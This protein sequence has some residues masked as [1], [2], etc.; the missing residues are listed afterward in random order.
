[1]ID[2]KNKYDRENFLDFLQNQLL[3]DDFVIDTTPLHFDRK[4]QNISKIT[5]L[6]FVKSLGKDVSNPLKVYELEH[7]SENDPRVSLKKE[8]FLLL[9]DDQSSRSLVI[10]KSNNSENYRFSLMTIDLRGEGKQI[11]KQ[12]SNPRRYSFYLGPDAKIKTPT[13]FLIKAEAK[14][15][16]DLLSR[17]SIE[18]VNKEFYQEVAR[19]FYELVG[20][21][22]RISTKQEDHKRILQ[23]PSADADK[24]RIH[25]EFAIRLIGRII[26][27]WFL[28]QKNSVGGIPLLPESLLSSKTVLASSDYYHSVLEKIFFEALNKEI[29][30]RNS[31]LSE[32]FNLI[33]FLNGGLFDPHHEDFYDGL[34]NKKL[35]IPDD[36]F[37]E[38]FS[39]LETYNFTIDEN[40]IADI[41]ISVDP[42]MLGRI[43]ENLLAEVNP[44]TGD[45]ARKSTGSYYTPRD[46]V[47]YMVDQ[48]LINYLLTKTSISEDK[49]AALVSYDEED[50]KEK[51]L[52]RGEITSIIGALDEI[53]IIDPACGSGAFPIGMLQK[54]IMIL[55]RIDPKAK[56]WFEKKIEGID[57]LI[58]EDYIKRFENENFDYIRKAGIIRDS[59]YGV[60]IQPIAVEVSKLRCFLTLI[61]NEE[62]DDSAPNRGVEPLPNLDYKI[63][64]GNSLIEIL[65]PELLQRTSDKEKNILINELRDLKDEVFSIHDSGLKKKKKEEV[66]RLIQTIIEYERSIEKETVWREILAKKNQ[67]KMFEDEHEQ[68][69][70]ADVQQVKLRK[71]IE[72]LDNLK[73]FTDEDHFEWHLNFN[74]VF[75]KGGFDVVIANPP[76]V[77]H[78]N[79]SKKDKAAISKRY[80]TFKGRADLYVAFYE[81]AYGLMRENATLAYITPNKF[82]RAGYGLPLRK[83][84]SEKT[85]ILSIVDFGDTQIFDATTYPCVLLF[86]KNNDHGY[87]FSFLSANSPEQLTI[88]NDI[89]K[90]HKEY[91][92]NEIWSF[93]DAD[94]SD[95]WKKC[96]KDSLT[97]DQ[98]IQKQFYR[99]IVTGLNEAFI[100]TKEE[101]A[102]LIAQNPRIQ[103]IIKPY[104]R[105]KEVK[106]WHSQTSSYVIFTY[107]GIDIG[108]YKEV[109]D[110]LMPF[111]KKLENRA[112]SG[113]HKW[114]ELQQPQTGIFKHFEKEKIIST[115]IAKRCEFTLDDTKSF[116]DATIFC[117]P[118]KDLYLLALLN[119]SLIEA[120]YKSI[121]SIVRGNFL[122]FKKIY[123][124]KMP[125]KKITTHEQ[126]PFISLVENIFTITKQADYTVNEEK[127]KRVLDIQKKLDGMVYELYGLAAE[128]IALVENI[129]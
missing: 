111:K 15:F 91:L 40:T 78:V 71:K 97:L 124:Y 108:K 32:D 127:Q 84:L 33:P 112:T 11:K 10:F 113:N 26:F 25:Q 4:P 16:E 8:A 22:V 55:Q 14:D 17:F 39:V 28:K 24:N 36:W 57:S 104:L 80:K 70:F 90:F 38:L 89:Q 69:T 23:L 6:G 21:Q 27:C 65:S 72:E 35:V 86:K 31:D 96:I 103:E 41:D 45:S 74:E 50:D 105:G 73:K 61:V 101:R 99:G 42:E 56:L 79:Y 66:N 75:E 81:M 93:E 54:I 52:I 82:F 47:E 63:M 122:R 37:T 19:F 95:I 13:N 60:D 68:I 123:L 83:F 48:S 119:S 110:Y 92:E 107:H 34:P 87:E 1:M 100:I 5:R 58:K 67:I 120:Y 29:D 114:Y 116:I 121:S 3:P 117:I 64:P 43:F 102:K 46:I 53:R 9:S 76:Y 118:L 77:S 98:Y 12:L 30:A 2:F 59:I 126:K 44:E 20:G 109:L 129:Q 49:L 62:I 18:V 94:L 88:N 85:E 125:I 7:N 128:E 115:D 106:R 51:P